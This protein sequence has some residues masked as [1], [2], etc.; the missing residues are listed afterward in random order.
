MRLFNSYNYKF[1]NF[2]KMK[3]LTFLA[4]IMLLSLSSCIIDGWDQGI[5][6]NGRV[7]EDDRDISGFTGVKVS[8]GIDVYLSQGSN[9]KVKVEA[10]EI[11]MK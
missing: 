10:D 4:I 8:S 3:K 6:G 5:S 11:S 2:L 1:S 7:V 9:F